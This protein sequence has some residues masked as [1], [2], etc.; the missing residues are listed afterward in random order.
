MYVVLIAVK[1][2][3]MTHWKLDKAKQQQKKTERRKNYQTDFQFSS[4]E[5]R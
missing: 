1:R 2:R 4:V 3:E 5:V